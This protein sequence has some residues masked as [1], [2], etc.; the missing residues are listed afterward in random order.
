MI[1]T[2]WSLTLGLVV[3]ILIGGLVSPV[4]AGVGPGP[5]RLEGGFTVEISA[6]AETDVVNDLLTATLSV[7]RSGPDSAR[8][9]ATVAGIMR[10]GLG[11]AERFPEVQVKS[12]AY[13][14]QPVFR[15]RDGK[16]EL[17]GWRISQSLLLES[18]AVADAAELIGR[19]QALDFQLKNIGFTVS[20]VKR[21]A[22]LT[23]LTAAA[24][25]AWRVKAEAAVRRL[26]GKVWRPHEL[27]IDD[28]QFHH[29]KP[30]L[31]VE[32]TRM[33]APVSP[34]L[35]TGVSRVRVRVNGTV[36]GR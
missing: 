28:E 17:V 20:S 22:Q 30:M 13:S 4:M 5:G 21:E 2:C 31:G 11:E 19:L 29:L 24:I 12:S 25:D 8:L 6:W 7:E 9:A 35:E 32:S 3:L 16:S 33:T 1:K 34:V 26:G 14:T 23:S 10:R 27:R 18:T 36:W 15:Q